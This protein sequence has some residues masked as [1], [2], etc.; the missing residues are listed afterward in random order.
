ME[1]VGKNLKQ[2][3]Q[4]RNYFQEYQQMVK[5]INE[6]P[7]VQRFLNQHQ[8]ELTQAD[9]EK[10]YSQL[11]EYIQQKEKFL[12]NDPTMIA[13]G[14]EPKLQISHHVID[15]LLCLTVHRVLFWQLLY[16]LDF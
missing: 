15:H 13:P 7:D 8:A 14:Y 10:S 1:D 11:Y 16:F 12:A 3:L 9:I 5:Q 6:N 4:K 2:I